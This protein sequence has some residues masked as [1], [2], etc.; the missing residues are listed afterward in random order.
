MSS[1]RLEQQIRFIVEIDKLKAVLR[2]SYLMDES[3]RENTAEH[4]WHVT[5]LAILFAEYANEPVDILRVVKMLLIHDVV[6][7]DAGDT[8]AYDEVGALL[9]AE[10]EGK[11]ADRIFKLLPHDQACELRA[12]WDEYEDGATP[13]ARYAIALDRFIPM[14]HNY[15][16][17]GRAWNENGVTE[18]RVLKRNAC[19]N[20]GA[21]DIWSYAQSLVRDAVAKGY[22]KQKDN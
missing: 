15:H 5:L 21:A 7:I 11:A 19:I 4:S 10:R 16:S 3:R 17:Q 20:D 9:K 22:L 18:D 12:L 2:R 8:F 14:L 1:I 13:E 6:E